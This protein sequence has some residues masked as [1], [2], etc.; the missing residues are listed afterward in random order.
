SEHGYRSAE[1]QLADGEFHGAVL[2]ATGNPFLIGLERSIAT[3]VQLTT[4]LKAAA[5]QTPRDPIPL[6]FEVYSAIADGD[7]ERARQAT[8][9]L[10][11]IAWEDLDESLVSPGDRRESTK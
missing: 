1:G 8:L 3:A 11:T 7:S 4:M 10:L 2:T 5:S 9:T 6:H